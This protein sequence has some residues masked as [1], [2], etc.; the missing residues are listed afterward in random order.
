MT[1]AQKFR[2]WSAISA[3]V[4]IVLV[5]VCVIGAIWASPP[6]FVILSKIGATFFVIFLLSLFIQNIA[7]G[8]CS[9][10]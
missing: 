10:D 7:K 8:Y 3:I 2:F 4:S 6:V 9:N 1:S 5:A